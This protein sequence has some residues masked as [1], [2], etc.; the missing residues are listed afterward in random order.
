MFKPYISKDFVV[1]EKT[2]LH[3]QTNKNYSSVN[4]ATLSLPCLNYYRNLFYN[5]I[6][7]KIVPSNIQNLLTPIG[8]AYWIMDDGSLQNKGLH[9]NTY[10]FNTEDIFNLK[11]TLENM[12]G[13][14]SLKCSIHKHKKGNRIYIWEES[15]VLLRAN[16][17][18]FMHEDMLYK[19]NFDKFK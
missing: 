15:M 7:L 13:K 2:F 5:S 6:N 18:Q 14:N 4:F 11:I 12:F 16:I 8:L 19:I 1:K 3:K 17:S 10:G 9:L